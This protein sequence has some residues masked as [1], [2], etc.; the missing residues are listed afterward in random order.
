MFAQGAALV[1]TM[2]KI[3]FE[4]VSY[5]YVFWAVVVFISLQ[6][7][8]APYGRYTRG[9]WGLQINGKLAWFL[10]EIPSIL[11]PLY[12]LLITDSPRISHTPNRIL[13]SCFIIHY[14]QRALIFPFLIRGGKPTPLVPFVLALVFCLANGY[15]QAGHL[16][17]HA[18]F[19]DRSTFNPQFY[20]GLVM[21]F[22][23]MFINIHSDH[24]LRNLR[25]PGEKGY[26]IPQGGM[27]KYVS[28]ANFFG[29]MCEWCG[30]AV[31]C[32]TLP[33]YS[34]ALF[35]VCNIGP[36]ACQ[37]HRYYLEKFEDYPK[38]R[39]AVIPFLI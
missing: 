22:A 11:V 37:H 29:E 18:E 21:F 5:V 15:V 26:K 20:L 7:V 4:V 2:D 8:N 13:L 10:Q 14:L 34:F 16:L 24:I 12:L 39:K 30:F 19:G 38:E 31:A 17:Y 9:G 33:A 25:K 3:V 36:R 28:G 32:G 6:F 35:T 23:G 27:F 1:V